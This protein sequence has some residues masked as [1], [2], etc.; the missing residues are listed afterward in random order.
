LVT[1]SR[2]MPLS[3]TLLAECNAAICRLKAQA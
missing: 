3:L 2:V 1:P